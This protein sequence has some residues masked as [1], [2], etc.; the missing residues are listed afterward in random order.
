MK[1]IFLLTLA[2][3]C[4]LMLSRDARAQKI[5]GYTSME[6]DEFNNTVEAYSETTIDFDLMENYN[7]MVSLRVTGDD[8]STP[9]L[10]TKNS[11]GLPFASVTEFFT[12]TAGV[13]YTARG[14]HKALAKLNEQ[15]QF[16]PYKIVF[17]DPWWYGFFGSQVIDSPWFYNFFNQG[18]LADRKRD[19]SIMN[20]GTTY[21]YASVSIPAGPKAT[22]SAAQT[23]K[24][25]GTA[26]F[27]V[28]IEN[29]TPISYQWLF[30]A[31]S[32]AGNNPM[33]TFSPSATSASVTT[34]GHWFAKPNDPCQAAANAVYTIKCVVTFSGGKKITAQ[35]K[36]TV[37]ALWNP[38]GKVDPNEARIEGAPR[39]DPDANGIWRITGMGT[40]RRKIPT[41]VVLIPNTSQFFNK[42]DAHEQVHLDQWGPGQLFGGVHN[43]DE[44][45]DRI[46]NF[47]GATQRELLDKVEAE[48]KTYTDEQDKFVELKHSE[49]EQQAYAVSDQIAPKYVYQLCPGSNQ[50]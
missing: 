19:S 40:L 41:K 34:D 16:Y 32:G 14:T 28:T 31:P 5:D 3:A 37:D 10:K 24:D 50:L 11:N 49:A 30:T 7:V 21:D 15:E 44:F 26:S 33:V 2:A 6:Y 13:T 25:G 1:K 35:S 27:S 47:T 18:Y 22:M 8:G 36:L 39:M 38:A 23:I 46:K 17:Y 42:A 12:G 48:L 4:C 20:L 45:Y 43:P 9:V 29:G